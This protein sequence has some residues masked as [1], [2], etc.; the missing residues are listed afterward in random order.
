MIAS[1]KTAREQAAIP[2]WLVKVCLALAVANVALCPAAYFASWWIY[3]PEGLGIPTDFINVWAAGRLVLEGVPAQAYDW[4]IQKQVEVAKL[5]Q[6]FTGYFAWHYPP[7]FLLVASLL[8]MLP[9]SVGYAGWVY[10]SMLPYLA[11]MRAIV[12][13][14]LGIL[15]ALAIPTVLM[16]TY[17]GQNGFLTAALIGGTIYLI[18]V[19]PVLAGIC[20]G[21]LTYKPQY[22]L[23]FPVVLIAAGHWRVF[24]SAAVTAVALALA[25]AVA[26]GFESWLAFFHWMP[27]FSQAFL[28]EGKATWW[29]LQSIFSLVRYFGGSEPLG[30]AFQWVL[31]A[32]VA[33]VLALM[34]RS[35][36]PYTLKA[37]A[38]AVGTLLTTPYLFVY[39]MMVLAIPIGFIVRIGLKSGF[40]SYELPALGA[41]VALITCYMFTGIPTGFG[42]TLLVGA[43]ILRRA[44]SWW[45]HE[46]APRAVAVGAAI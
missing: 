36:V 14:N 8:A 28:T 13:H 35:R 17:A 26:L 44:G 1:P 23:L 18:P 41:V 39:D 22:G 3:N 42:A 7:P 4:D 43:L 38:L 20:L 15:I 2:E 45:R 40:R 6:D 21:L 33:V 5:G 16:N 31:T 12:G 29:K 32:S 9:Y 25:S 37:A 46:P 11:V 30:W 10:V 24:I 34:W 27:R 19:R